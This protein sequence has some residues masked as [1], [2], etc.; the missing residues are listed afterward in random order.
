MR[1]VSMVKLVKVDSLHVTF[2]KDNENVAVKKL[3]VISKLKGRAIVNKPV[4]I[5]S[6]HSWT[7]AFLTKLS[8]SWI[9][10]KMGMQPFENEVED[11][12]Y[13]SVDPKTK[14]IKTT[15]YHFNKNDIKRFK[16]AK[17]VPEDIDE[18]VQAENGAH[19]EKA[20]DLATWLTKWERAAGKTATVVQQHPV[21]NVEGMIGPDDL[22]EE[23][24]EAGP[25]MENTPAGDESIRKVSLLQNEGSAATTLFK[26]VVI[27][28][29]ALLIG[30]AI[31]ASLREDDGAPS[32]QE[33]SAT[34][35]GHVHAY[36]T[37][38]PNSQSVLYHPSQMSDLE[39]VIGPSV[40]QTTPL[41]LQKLVPFDPDEQQQA[42]SKPVNPSV[43][44]NVNEEVAQGTG[45]SGLLP[46]AMVAGGLT[47]GAMFR[48]IIRGGK[49][50]PPV[51]KLQAANAGQAHV[52]AGVI[53]HRNH[54]QVMRDLPVQVR[55]QLDSFNHQLNVLYDEI[56]PL[57]AKK[58]DL[59][60][61]KL[62]KTPE[63][64]DVKAAI[65]QAYQ[66][67]SALRQAKVFLIAQ[68]VELT[69]PEKVVA[70]AMPGSI[71]KGTTFLHA[72]SNIDNLESITTTGIKKTSS[73]E[74]PSGRFG[75]NLLGRGTYL[76]I[77]GGY[78]GEGYTHALF[79]ETVETVPTIRIPY[80]SSLQHSTYEPLH[81]SR[82]DVIEG[83]ALLEDEYTVIQRDREP[84]GDQECNLRN[85][86]HCFRV[87]GLAVPDPKDDSK[88][89]TPT[90][91]PNDWRLHDQ[92]NPA[93][94]PIG[95]AVVAA[96]QVDDG[97]PPVDPV[98]RAL[99][100][101]VKQTALEINSSKWI[102]PNV[103]A[104]VA[105]KRKYISSLSD[106]KLVGI[107]KNKE[108]DIAELLDL[109]KRYV[110]SSGDKIQNDGLDSVNRWLLTDK[111]CVPFLSDPKFID[112][113]FALEELANRKVVCEGQPYNH[114][115]IVQRPNITL[116]SMIAFGLTG[117]SPAALECLSLNSSYGDE[118]FLQVY[119]ARKEIK[120]LLGIVEA[121]GGQVL[122]K[123]ADSQDGYSIQ[124]WPSYC[125]NLLA[126]IDQGI[127]MH[128]TKDLLHNDMRASPHF[129]KH[130][131]RSGLENL[132]MWEKG[133]H[134]DTF[135]FDKLVNYICT[136]DQILF[137]SLSHTMDRLHLLAALMDT[138]KNIQL[139][140]RVI[141]P[142]E[143]W[144]IAQMST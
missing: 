118:D 41:T 51:L 67:I 62:D 44:D 142:R 46:A 59:F 14:K 69:G 18:N 114:R 87:I 101:Q 28:G 135:S 107:Y 140:D 86:L 40:L 103:E 119:L 12:T 139:S 131:A 110:A 138:E 7:V 89:G 49:P 4:T 58:E 33:S 94:Q 23:V 42:M 83:F 121:L 93:A 71:P 60:A 100:L 20:T 127:A 72:T 84:P 43:G 55:E 53:K 80:Q 65:Q 52:G 6:Y 32:S 96:S 128:E 88:W 129:I 57:D 50:K 48:R 134:I 35:V 30:G 36:S 117:N 66:K 91:L 102:F 126:L 92:W 132:V 68:Q 143:I 76:G 56:R 39:E 85:P 136:T 3:S 61:K 98:R 75:E 24:A 124:Q 9:G 90:P 81:L 11:Y 10:Q 95:D 122:A 16:E 77:A 144:F 2:V 133:E 130:M 115:L 26:G 19:P 25:L 38:G 15:V 21:F 29:G 125:A 97:A 99:V 104:V 113:L 106:K 123:P 78:I 109:C 54:E 108:K 17:G 13:K 141:S 22:G 74:D 34:D 63:M 120:G 111:R 37:L 45:N 82:E 31:A 70:L 112:A 47:I 116:T 105:A 5:R 79:I 137:P 64:A 27:G 1:G 73:R 8:H